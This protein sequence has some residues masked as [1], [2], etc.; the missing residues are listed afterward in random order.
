MTN[1]FVYE[2]ET[3]KDPS[4]LSEAVVDALHQDGEGYPN[5]RNMGVIIR[6]CAPMLQDGFDEILSAWEMQKD[7]VGLTEDMG[8]T[9]ALNQQKRLAEENADS[10]DELRHQYFMAEGVLRK[11]LRNMIRD[12]DD[13]PV[14]KG[15][16]SDVLETQLGR[17][18]TVFEQ[19]LEK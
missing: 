13:T 1:T 17:L 12:S 10:P 3:W 4:S 5:A 2:G 6:C 11:T 7:E 14:R 18:K 19:A 15:T 9:E 16:L 8:V